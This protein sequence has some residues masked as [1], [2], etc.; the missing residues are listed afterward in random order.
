MAA[1]FVDTLSPVVLVESMSRGM[2]VSV[3]L[4]DSEAGPDCGSVE[5]TDVV[6]AD[7]DELSES[8][9]VVVIDDAVVRGGVLEV[10]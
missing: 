3:S 6:P 9:T 10:A 2:E 7:C 8:V 4:D 1:S 5:A